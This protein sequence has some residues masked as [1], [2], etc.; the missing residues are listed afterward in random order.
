VKGERPDPDAVADEAD[1]VK[2]ERPDPRV[3]SDTQAA[4]RELFGVNA[5]SIAQ[6]GRY[7][8]GLKR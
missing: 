3:R 2:T 6:A 8:L 7:A 4:L 5:Q 1:S